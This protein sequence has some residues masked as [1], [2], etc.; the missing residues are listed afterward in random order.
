[1]A[2]KAPPAVLIFKPEIEMLLVEEYLVELSV[3]T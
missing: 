1:M 3:L 2:T